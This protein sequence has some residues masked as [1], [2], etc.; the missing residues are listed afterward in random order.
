M[1]IP[2]EVMFLLANGNKLNSTNKLSLL[3]TNKNLYKSKITSKIKTNI[4]NVQNLV[5]NLKKYLNVLKKLNENKYNKLSN[6]LKQYNNNSISEKE[7]VKKVRSYNIDIT[8]LYKS[9]LNANIVKL[10]NFKRLHNIQIAF[11]I[12]NPN[13]YNNN[14]RQFGEIIHLAGNKVNDVLEYANSLKKSFNEKKYVKFREYM[15][16]FYTSIYTKRYP[17]EININ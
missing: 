14:N 1:K 17:K 15:N 16:N 11:N 12:N 10:Q 3:M 5:V 13:Y 7:F 4:K 8:K 9:E 2:N 6:I